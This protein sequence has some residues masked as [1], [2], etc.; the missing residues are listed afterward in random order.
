MRTRVVETIIVKVLEIKLSAKCKNILSYHKETKIKVYK[1]VISIGRSNKLR[2][3]S[4]PERLPLYK[5]EKKKKK[6]LVL[7]SQTNV[8]IDT[9]TLRHN[10]ESFSLFKLENKQLCEETV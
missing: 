1:L 2:G 4:Y 7:K 3:I 5:K 8:H 9:V 6:S 10:Q